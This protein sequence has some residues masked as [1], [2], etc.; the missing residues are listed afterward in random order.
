MAPAL[1]KKKPCE[2]QSNDTKA[3]EAMS[4]SVVQSRQLNGYDVENNGDSWNMD[5]IENFLDNTL[6]IPQNGQ[7]EIYTGVTAS[8][9][10]A[11]K[12]DWQEWADQLIT[13]N[14]GTLDS[15]WSDLLVDVNGP[16]PDAKLL[17]L[18]PNISTLQPQIHCPMPIGESCPLVGS[19]TA[20][21]TKSRMRW[22]PEL[23][24]V[25]VKAVNK[26]GGS[27]RA[28]PKGV[29]KL[30]NVESL[31]IYHVKSHLQAWKIKYRT[32]RFK[33][34]SSEGTSEKKSNTEAEM[35]SLDLKTT[36]GITEALRI[37]MEVQKQLHEQLEIQRNLQLRIEEQGKH[38]QMIFEQQR[39]ME[40]EKLKASSSNSYEPSPPPSVEKQLSFG[41]DKTE[42]SDRDH[43]TT[44]EV[45]SDL[46]ISSDEHPNKKDHAP[47][48]SEFSPPS[49][50][51]RP[52]KHES[53]EK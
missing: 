13:V 26:L 33:P 32:A 14:D 34:E 21:S 36:M 30:M 16:D 47:D 25:F 7:V 50:E 43:D 12:T 6:S 46:C 8:E 42:L 5:V 23:H 49:N 20:P 40:E 44:E 3:P 51:L 4:H 39:K 2:T 29:L 22:T 15:N 11:K 38:L 41:N 17:D 37:Q 45:A 48:I 9:D 27:E 1:F 19:P 31:T 35:T 18:P 52:M 10:H 53:S 24:E 28:T